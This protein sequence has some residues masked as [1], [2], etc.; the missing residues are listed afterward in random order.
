MS[1]FVLNKNAQTNGDHEVHNTTTG[2]PF[3]PNQES[4]ID[5]GTHPSCHS[6]V[7]EAKNRWP[8]HR[9]NGCYY[10]CRPCHTS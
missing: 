7:T 8:N 1:R 10:C 6:A 3:M 9:I 2:C 5:L 4:Q